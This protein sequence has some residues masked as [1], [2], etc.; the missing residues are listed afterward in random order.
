MRPQLP[1]NIDV[2]FIAGFGP[3]VFDADQSRSFYRETLGLPFKE[4]A[5]GYLHTGELDGA[6][7]FALW[8]LAQAAESCFGTDQ[9][10]DDLPVPQAWLEFD[11]GDID[12]ATKELKAQGYTLLIEGR[13]EPW[14]QIVTR[15]LGPEGLLV[16]ITHTP[17]MRK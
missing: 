13:K 4:D 9:W 12:A 2:L 11:V 8:P 10:P 6:K 16:G 7:H 17:S 14:G 5:S 3:I 1:K 15:L